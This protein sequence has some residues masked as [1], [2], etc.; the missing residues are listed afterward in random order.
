[1]TRASAVAASLTAVEFS[2]AYNVYKLSD[3]SAYTQYKLKPVPIT[4]CIS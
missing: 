2:S 4:L 3:H 1:V